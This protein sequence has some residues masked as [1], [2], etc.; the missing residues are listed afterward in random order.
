MIYPLI[1]RQ[2]DNGNYEII[3][4][5]RRKKAC[6]L[7]GIEEV[8]VIVK[9]LT[10]DEAI[11]YMVDS[12]KQREK[13]LPSEKAF[14]YK[15]RL[16]AEKRKAGR[17]KKENSAPVEQNFENK[18]T[19]DKIADDM[20]ESSSN[21]QRYI[22]LTELIPELLEYVDSERIGLRPAVEISYL[23]EEEQYVLLNSIKLLDST[24][25]LSQAIDLRKRSQENSLTAEYIDKILQQEKP[26]Q[27]EKIKLDS[28]R[29]HKILPKHLKS[30]KDIENFIIKC[31]EEHNQREKN[32]SRVR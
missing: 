29:V 31:I 12:N 16:D 27:V 13:V 4:G 22:R 18:T 10:D 17:P 2:K 28:K 20:G 6:E 14:A 7:A 25:T 30:D 1:V 5:H 21:V 24:P 15:M 32:K 11:I 26:N 8:P 23:R 19:R 3:S 9:D